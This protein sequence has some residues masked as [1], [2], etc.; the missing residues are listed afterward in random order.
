MTGRLRCPRY[1]EGSPQWSQ[2]VPL[3]T[4]PRRQSLSLSL[5]KIAPG[6]RRRGCVCEEDRVSVLRPLDG[7]AV[8]AGALRLRRADPVARAGRRGRG[9]GR[10]RRV[11]PRAPLR[12]PARI[13]VSAARG[14]RRADVEDRDRHRRHR[15]A[16]RE[17]ALHGRGR[18]RRR[19]PRRRS[20]AAGH[21]PRVAGA[22]D[23]RLAL[24][25]LPAGRGRDRRRHGT[26]PHPGVPGGAEG[27]GVR[28]TEPAADVSQPAGPAPPSSRT[29]RGCANGSGGAQDRPRPPPGRPPSA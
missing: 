23:R 8:V 16:L 25:R 15:H 9:G 19:P 5:G 12:A 20:A 6:R 28:P 4:R 11:L 26:P 2:T 14:G 13:A 27:G 3:L 21:Q 10:R 1:A 17:P 18:R 7:V 24:L 22:G 29:R